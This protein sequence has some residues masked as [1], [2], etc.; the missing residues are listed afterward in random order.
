MDQPEPSTL[1]YA[2]YLELDKIL[3]SQHPK[4][5]EA[6][7]RADSEMLFIVIHQAYELWFKQILFELDLVREIFTQ[8]WINDNAPDM[9]R[10]IHKLRRIVKILELLIHQVQVL[11]T[12]TSLEFYEFRDLLVPA[13]GFQSKQFRLI[14][15]KLGLKMEHRHMAQYYKHTRSGGLSESDLREISEVEAQPTLKEA[16]EKWL[17]R[18]PFFADE[19]W[20]I[21]SADQAMPQ[22]MI[23]YK[24]AYRAS[25]AN[26]EE[27]GLAH[28]DEVFLQ[29]GSGD[30]SPQA[31]R[32]M[33]FINS[34]RDLPVLQLPLELLTTL[35]DVDALLSDWRYRHLLM[36]RRMIGLRVGT[37]GTTGAGYLEGALSKHYIF[38][39]LTEIATFLIAP[40]W[41]PQLPKQLMDK[42]SFNL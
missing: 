22:F 23:D 35:I 16:I 31:M 27:A 42:L 18:I 39:E 25:L 4:S 20:P 17:E 19:Y 30:F 5:V 2:D 41:L 12:M 1:Y 8:D 34:Y 29:K 14:E 32:A 24:Q 36:V 13:S 7:Q 26:K 3:N 9:S 33:L 38:K 21:G 15:A 28:F 37:G 40:G 11:E 6:H 10:V